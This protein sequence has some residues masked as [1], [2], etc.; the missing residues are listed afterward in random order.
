MQRS[1]NVVLIVGLTACGGG[2]SAPPAGPGSPPPAP[3]PSPTATPNAYAAAC[4][5][6]LPSSQFA[7]GY[8]IK[9][10]LEPTKNKKVLNGSP[11]LRDLA[12]C[13]AAGF[14]NTLICNTRKEDHPQ[15]VPCDHYFS[16]MSD[17][18]VPGPNWYQDL[19][20]PGGAAAERLVKCGNADTTCRLKPENQYLLDITEVGRYVACA[21]TGG[22]GAG[23]CGDCIILTMAQST[24]SLGGLCKHQ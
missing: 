7:Y 15:R 24:G 9:V 10:Q 17:E 5:T 8:G 4:G 2:G 12:Y 22:A 19:G 1:L 14:A 13:D 3:V 20:W 6:P 23:T 11:S 16:G 18:G 21:G